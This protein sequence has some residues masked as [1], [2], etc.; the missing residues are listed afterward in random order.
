[1]IKFEEDGNTI[2]LIAFKYNSG[3][4]YFKLPVFVPIKEFIGLI[5]HIE[6]NNPVLK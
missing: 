6:E 5:G 3:I 4:L 1:M 2:F